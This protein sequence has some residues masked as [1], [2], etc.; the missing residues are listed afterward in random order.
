MYWLFLIALALPF[1][2]PSGSDA[3]MRRAAAAAALPEN[4]NSFLD[5]K[6]RFRPDGLLAADRDRSKTYERG[7]YNGVKYRFYHADGRGTFDTYEDCNTAKPGYFRQACDLIPTSYTWDTRCAEDAVTGRRNCL[8]ERGALSLF[9]VEDG[10]F[11]VLVG[12]GVDSQSALLFENEPP[13][14]MDKAGWIGASAVPII[15]RLKGA[16]RV[17]TRYKKNPEGP[18]VDKVTELSGLSEVLEYLRFAVCQKGTCRR[19]E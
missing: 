19:G 10:I 13:V 1:F 16:R 17:T 12:P 8:A 4:P 14:V 15:E 9:F 2:S 5:G 6:I 11:S 18:N 7:E 3:Q